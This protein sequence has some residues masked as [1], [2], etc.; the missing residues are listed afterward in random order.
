MSLDLFRYCTESLC[1]EREKRAMNK[2]ELTSLG[3]ET[4]LRVLG[5]LSASLYTGDALARTYRTA[6]YCRVTP[7]STGDII[8]SH[9]SPTSSTTSYRLVLRH[10]PRIPR[11][12]EPPICVWTPVSPP[13]YPRPIMPSRRLWSR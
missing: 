10:K 2:I 8:Q 4:Q 11:H 1:L 12:S 3:Q 9:G 13:S 6:T 5:T 7:T